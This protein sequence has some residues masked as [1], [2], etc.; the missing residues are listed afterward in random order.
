M[1]NKLFRTIS[2]ALPASGPS[3]QPVGQALSKK[4]FG[5]KL[6]IT[7]AAIVAIAV[8]LTAVFYVP[9]SNADVISL[10]VHYSIG[11]KLTYD[12]TTSTS[13]QSGNTSTNLSSEGTL[14]VEVQNKIADTYTLNYTTT[15]NLASY[16]MTTSR[17]MEVKETDMVNLLTLLP[18]AL[19]QYAT[20]TNN[21]NPTE[22]AVFNQT[23]AKVGDEW[24]IP[25]TTTASSSV[26]ATEINVK[27]VAI[28]DLS[29]KAGTFKV[30]RIDFSQT[31]PQQNS[32]R[33]LS[34]NFDV[35]GQSYL[36]MGT[37]KQIQSTVELTMSTQLGTNANYNTI[38]TFTS[39]LVKDQIP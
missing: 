24:Q 23:Q 8:I 38:I 31:N 19:Q 12:I 16:S 34:L 11:E 1:E 30:F 32:A 5:K 26:P 6:Y 21:S 22:T 10:G 9:S 14:T 33:S 2:A 27:F 36:Q 37:C 3:E 17:L 4:R 13:S 28:Q 20:P 39:T 29:V 15:S 18:I 35:S 7:V 25:L